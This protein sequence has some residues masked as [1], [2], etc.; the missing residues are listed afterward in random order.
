M[1]QLATNTALAIS[2][3]RPPGTADIRLSSE[4]P[5]LPA[6]E[7]IHLRW[8]VNGPELSLPQFVKDKLLHPSLSSSDAQVEAVINHHRL[9]IGKAGKF[10]VRQ[11][12]G[13]RFFEAGGEDFV[14][15]FK[16]LWFKSSGEDFGF[17]RLAY[18]I[19]GNSEFGVQRGDPF[20]IALVIQ[21]KKGIDSRKLEVADA[22]VPIMLRHVASSWKPLLQ[23][24]WQ[25]G[26]EFS[27]HNN[28]L[29]EPLFDSSPQLRVP[30]RLISTENGYS[31][32]YSVMPLRHPKTNR[33]VRGLLRSDR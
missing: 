32:R 9:L 4:T 6:K 29:A 15:P 25:V 33:A 3:S 13:G 7:E 24:G 2:E 28:R 21:G 11:E 23:A 18:G 14:Y 8:E 12:T 17:A 31:G 10:E 16:Y 27:S 5:C 22:A 20:C 1:G 26:V 19:S 30:V